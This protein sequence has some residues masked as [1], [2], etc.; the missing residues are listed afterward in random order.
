MN[1]WNAA[2]PIGDGIGLLRQRRSG[3]AGAQW[4]RKPF[5]AAADYFGCGEAE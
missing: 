5:H 3:D 1:L 2:L 4:D